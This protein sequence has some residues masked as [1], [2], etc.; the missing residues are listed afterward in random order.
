MLAG[1]NY[2]SIFDITWLNIPYSVLHY[3]DIVDIITSKI[4]DL[5]PDM[6]GH[7]CNSSDQKAEPIGSHEFEAS[8]FCIVCLSPSCNREW[9]LLSNTMA[10]M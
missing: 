1:I 8:L 7:V 3:N 4:S 9:N 6:I 2:Y 5:E 10:T